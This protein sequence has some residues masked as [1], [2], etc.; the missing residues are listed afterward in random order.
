M[1]RIRKFDKRKFHGNKKLDNSTR[2][3]PNPLSDQNDSL[4]VS[5]SKK[6]ISNTKLDVSTSGTVEENSKGHSIFNLELLQLALSKSCVCKA[7]L[8]GNLSLLE[9]DKPRRG[10]AVSYVLECDSCGT[11][12]EFSNSKLLPSKAYEVNVRMVYGLRSIGK[13]YAGGRMLCAMLDLPKPPQKFIRVNK[14]IAP[15]VETIA[16]DSMKN[17]AREAVVENEE[18]ERPTDLTVAIDGTWQKRGYTSLNGVVTLTSFDTG[19]V[20]DYECLT[21]FCHICKNVKNTPHDCKANFQGSSGG[22][23]SAGAIAMFRRSE[24]ARGVRY[25]K[26]LGDGDSKGFQSVVEDQPYGMCEL[27]KLECLG[28]VQKRMG[29]RLRSLCKR[30][31]GKKLSDGKILRGTGRLTDPAIDKLQNYYGLAIR[32]NKNDL[33]A[34]IK[35]VW[36]TYFHKLSTDEKPQHQLCTKGADSWCGYNKSIELKQPYTHKNSLPEAVLLAIKPI[37]QDLSKPDLL[38]K[39]L[40]GHTQNPN[41]SFNNVIWKRV[42]KTEFVGIETLKLGVNDAVLSFND[43]NIAKSSVL[44]NLGCTLSPN[45]IDGLKKIDQL[46]IF[47]AQKATL[48]I[49]K[50]ARMKKRQI[51]RKREEGESNPEY[52]PGL[53]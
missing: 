35:A 20:I 44:K 29:S 52:G 9:I 25:T 27:D 23:E 48:A 38:K 46:R 22:M 26:Y 7:C 39:C 37:Y 43:G 21:K 31:R 32:R 17:A 12:T 5:A 1:P 16:Q 28:H 13:G 19:K 41:E 6:K 50:E 47:Q 10:L 2:P 40:H 53:F 36:A 49:T 4:P 24:E 42:P 15:A 30:M 34:M 51:K 45:T 11:K 8:K 33:Q 14:L 3:S 18:S